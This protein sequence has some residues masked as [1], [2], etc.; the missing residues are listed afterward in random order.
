MPTIKAAGGTNSD[1]FSN[2]KFADIPP[3]GAL[4]NMY[5]SCVTNGDTFGISVGDRDLIANGTEPNIEESADVINTDRDQVLFNEPVGG[6]HIFV[7]VTVTTEINV[8]LAIR[9][10]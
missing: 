4:L 5:V 10:L 2:L 7:P 6:G 1:L 3:R 8:M 9:F